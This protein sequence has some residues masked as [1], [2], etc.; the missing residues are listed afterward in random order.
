M[1]L[2]KTLRTFGIIA[3]LIGTTATHSFALPTHEVETIYFSDATYSKEV[4]AV[5]LSC[6]G[7]VYHEGKT[8]RYRVKSST[9]CR[10][11]STLNEI[12]CYV[13]SV[14]TTCPANICD[15]PLFDCQ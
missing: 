15:S 1:K 4:G 5:I 8:S 13:N 14:H 10:G 9:P 6:Q 12:D 2:T 7:G 11:G 3:A